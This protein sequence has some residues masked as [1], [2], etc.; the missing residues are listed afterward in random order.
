MLTNIDDVLI[1]WTFLFWDQPFFCIYFRQTFTSTLVF[2]GRSLLYEV[3]SNNHQ[4]STPL[5]A[6]Y[7]NRKVSTSIAGWRMVCRNCIPIAAKFTDKDIVRSH[8]IFTS[9]LYNTRESCIKGQSWNIVRY[10]YCWYD[11]YD[12]NIANTT[13]TK[14]PILLILPIWYQKPT[15]DNFEISS[16]SKDT[17]LTTSCD[18][19]WIL[20]LW[21]SHDSKKRSSCSV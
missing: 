5:E 12:I 9:E 20:S 21:G 18:D 8:N 3:I 16:L 4:I 11:K 1:M 7:Q 17:Y 14:W 2:L 15:T 13:K 19:C 10:W 6:G